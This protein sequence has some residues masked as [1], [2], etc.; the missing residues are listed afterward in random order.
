MRE[1]DF[2][3]ALETE[4]MPVRQGRAGVVRMGVTYEQV[5]TTAL[6]FN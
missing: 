2:A 1:T 3:C 4:D 6:F 5:V